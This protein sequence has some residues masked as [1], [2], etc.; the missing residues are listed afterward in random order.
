MKKIV[1]LLRVSTNK[2]DLESQKMDLLK[3][4]IKEGYKEDEI[5]WIEAKGASAVKASA[6]YLQM[7]ENVKESLINN[8][9]KTLVIW[10]LNRLG[11]KKK[12]IQDMINWFEE[13][14]IQLI[15]LN[16]FVK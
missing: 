4:L 3:Y 7:L 5:E 9:I 16:P 8:N 12:Y 11:R 10:H 13:N 6:S 14:K 15:C 1:A 2:Q